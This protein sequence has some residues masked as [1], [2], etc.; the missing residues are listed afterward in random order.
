MTINTITVGRQ[1]RLKIGASTLCFARWA[2]RVT[3][4]LV[5][6][7]DGTI[8]GNL[9]HPVNRVRKGRKLIA[10]SLFI[11]ITEPVFTFLLAYL[12]VT[13]GGGGVYT[14]GATGNLVEVDIYIDM[15]AAVH[16]FTNAVCTGWALRGAKGSRPIQLQMDIVAEDEIDPGGSP[17]ADAALTIADIFSFTD[18]TVANFDDGANN[19]VALPIDR[20]LLQVDYGVV[21][22]HNSSVTRTG[23]A[24]GS[25]TAILATSTPYTST[26]KDIYWDYRDSEGPLDFTLTIANADATIEFT[27]PAGVPITEMPGVMGKADQIRTPVTW[28]LN[29]T[30]N[31]G[32][33][34]SPLTITVT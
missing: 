1:A 5:K 33:F 3:R 9:W 32:T 22:E 24:A 10:G 4:E 21:V 28:D 15:G 29:R 18:I 30:D 11:D 20:F 7:A 14:L 27:A 13:S 34:V 23:A 6:N 26:R 25:G 19:T 8:C 16:K 17:F 2:P 12:G 31:A